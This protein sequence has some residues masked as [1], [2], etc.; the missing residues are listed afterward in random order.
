MSVAIILLAAGGSSRMGTPKQM[1][2][3]HGTPMLRNAIHTAVMS[4][5]DH[6]L[7]VLGSNHI[8]H[9]DLINDLN[10]SVVVNHQWMLGMGSSLKAGFNA[11]LSRDPS[12][13]AVVV[14]LCD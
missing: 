6:T 1:M 7:V 8:E 11:V 2:P 12:T 10:V 9:A 3:V 14:M 5:A 13:D 4:K